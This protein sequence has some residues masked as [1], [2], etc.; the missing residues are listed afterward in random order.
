[1]K[2]RKAVKLLD[3]LESSLDSKGLLLLQVFFLFFF[4]KDE[5]RFHWTDRIK[6]FPPYSGNVK[7]VCA[8]KI[9][10]SWTKN[11]SEREISRGRR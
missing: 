1:M 4:K 3:K 11:P 8:C 2:S 10:Q 5:L 6:K 9:A 7:K